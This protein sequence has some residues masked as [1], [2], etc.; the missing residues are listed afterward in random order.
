M[1]FR[2]INEFLDQMTGSEFASDQTIATRAIGLLTLPFRFLFQFIAFMLTYW[3]S[4]RSFPAFLKAAPAMGV[5]G[6]FLFSL[7]LANLLLESSRVAQYE[8]RYAYELNKAENP[9]MAANYAEKL[10]MLMP[11]VDR[12]RYQLGLAKYQS[13]DVLGALDVMNYIAEQREDPKALIWLANTIT[14]DRSLDIPDEERSVRSIAYFESAIANLD[15]EVDMKVITEAHLGMATVC[16]RQSIAA[17][18]DEDRELWQNRAIQS[19]RE[20]V[21]YDIVYPGQ[22]EAFP[23]I[24]DFHQRNGDSSKAKS[25]LME[26]IGKI[27]PIARRLPDNIQIRAILV[28]SCLMVDDFDYAEEVIKEGLQ[29]ATTPESRRNIRSLHSEVLIKKAD[30]VKDLSVKENFLLRLAAISEAVIVNPRCYPAYSRLIDYAEPEDPV[31][32]HEKWLRRSVIGSR[33]PAITNIILGLRSMNRG[34]FAEGQRHW[35]IAANQTSY[36]PLIV[37]SMI[38]YA[39]AKTPDRF[40]NLLDIAS[41]GIETF[42]SQ[43]VFYVTRGQMYLKRQRYEY[44]AKDLESAVKAIPDLLELRESL[45]EAYQGMGNQEKANLHLAEVDR[46]KA[47]AEAARMTRIEGQ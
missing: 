20:V 11:E 38:Q 6:V 27:E 47:E 40:D 15:P 31:E 36:T 28:S 23:R 18:S 8:V 1:V 5:G 44:A 19:L 46:L 26:A 7:I 45:V 34:E 35:R 4:S 16:Q 9:E 21:Q 32:N 14:S 33:T 39:A 12:Y 25:V 3:A 22:V 10:M 2:K 43:P 29:L 30:Y 42:P 37:N 24:I 13:G 41:V 17:E